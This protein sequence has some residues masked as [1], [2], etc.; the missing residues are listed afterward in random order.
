MKL[1]LQQQDELIKAVY[2]NTYDS[3]RKELHYGN[4]TISKYTSRDHLLF[5][6]RYMY[7]K[8]E[9]LESD[10][11]FLKMVSTVLWIS[12]V[13]LLLINLFY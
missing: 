8:V 7:Y 6:M 3:I 2:N 11:L 10:I 4:S 9:N 13:V 5:R 12:T 1:T